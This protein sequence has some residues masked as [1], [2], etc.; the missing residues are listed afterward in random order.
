MCLDFL[1]PRTDISSHALGDMVPPDELKRTVLCVRL[2][3]QC[4]THKQ[5]VPRSEKAGKELSRNCS[6]ERLVI[7]GQS[8]VKLEECHS[9][10]V[11]TEAVKGQLIKSDRGITGQATNCTDGKD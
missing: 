6:L 2:W 4:S 9:M 7:R 11:D 10:L 3:L 1:F 8:N 5:L